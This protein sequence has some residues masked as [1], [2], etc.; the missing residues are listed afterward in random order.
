MPRTRSAR[1]IRVAT[2]RTH[3]ACLAPPRHAWMGP[4]PAYCATVAD[5][6]PRPQRA[7]GVYQRRPVRRPCATAGAARLAWLRRARRHRFS[8]V[9]HRTDANSCRLPRRLLHVSRSSPAR[10]VHPRRRPSLTSN[11]PASTPGDSKTSATTLTGRLSLRVVSS[12]LRPLVPSPGNVRLCVRQRPARFSSASSLRGGCS[13]GASLQSRSQTLTPE[14]RNARPASPAL[15]PVASSPRGLPRRWI[16]TS[17]LPLTSVSKS[18][19]ATVHNSALARPETVDSSG[20]RRNG[21]SPAA[22]GSN[23]ELG[24]PT[25][26]RCRCRKRPAKALAMLTSS[27]S[28]RAE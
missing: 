14:R 26:R 19:G 13:N 9:T 25:N 10:R 16:S 27:T 18:P 4:R 21:R 3:S 28:P 2:A 6:P 24:P 20:H 5:P 8:E 12:S 11:A 7:R 15:A 17:G 1:L 22:A 23:A